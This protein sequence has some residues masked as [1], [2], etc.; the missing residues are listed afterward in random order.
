M[1]DLTAIPT[2]ETPRLRLRRPGAGDL[3]AFAELHADPEVMRYLGAGAAIDRDESWRVVAMILGH[4]VLR[5]F[6]PFAV[7][8]RATGRMIGR[9]GVWQ[10]E[11][12][13]GPE[14][15]WTLARAS[16]GR[17]LA[18]E[19]AAAARDYALGPLGIRQPYVL[20]HPDN[21]ASLRVAEKI[22]GRFE[23]A[24]TLRGKPVRVYRIDS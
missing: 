1:L 17:G 8:E 20:I 11:G 14:L 23:R 16:W 21:A 4:W 22:G 18:S 2:L 9:V 15:I 5:G 19:A 24:D 13:P 12:W 7:E 3:D 10:P 6:G